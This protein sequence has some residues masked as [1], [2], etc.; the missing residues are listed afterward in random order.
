LGRSASQCTDHIRHSPCLTRHQPFRV[1]V[2][3]NFQ[4]HDRLGTQLSRDDMI[5]TAK[6]PVCLEATVTDFNFAIRP[7]TSL[8]EL[9]CHPAGCLLTFLE[10]FLRVV[11]LDV[12]SQI[13][14]DEKLGIAFLA[15]CP[16]F[17]AG[18]VTDLV[19]VALDMYRHGLTMRKP[20][21]TG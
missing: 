18:N 16:H 7:D 10:A 6:L 4:E 14:S 15:L 3:V 2:L 17:V 11:M 5:H 9:G 8:S 1:F 12:P 19:V 21:K 13:L 20:R